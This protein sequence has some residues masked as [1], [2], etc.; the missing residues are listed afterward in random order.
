MDIIAIDPNPRLRD[1]PA[2]AAANNAAFTIMD[3]AYKMISVCFF[4]T[5]KF[6]S[7]VYKIGFKMTDR[8]HRPMFCD[9]MMA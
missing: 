9:G 7:A 8:Y 2:Q 1:F 4:I 5:V 6:N 3:T